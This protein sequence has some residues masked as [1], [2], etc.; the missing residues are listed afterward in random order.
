MIRRTLIPLGLSAATLLLTLGTAQAQVIR[1][2]SLPGSPTFDCANPTNARERDACARYEEGRLEGILSQGQSSVGRIGADAASPVDDPFATP[3]VAETPTNI[4]GPTPETVEPTPEVVDALPTVAP[5]LAPLQL[6]APPPAPVDA[7]QVAA[8]PVPAPTADPNLVSR[9]L[10]AM[11]GLDDQ[12][13][14][15]EQDIIPSPLGVEAQTRRNT[16]RL[17]LDDNQGGQA[18]EAFGGA[19]SI[20]IIGG[21]GGQGLPEGEITL[22][23]SPD[24]GLGEEELLAAA[25][26]GS[27][28]NTSVLF[29][30]DPDLLAQAGDILFGTLVTR[31]LSTAPSAIIGEIA[32]PGPLQG[33][34]LI[35]SFSQQYD[36]LLITF[37]RLSLPDGR[38]ADIEAVAIDANT[39]LSTLADDVAYHT[40]K[41]Y[42]LAAGAAFLSGFGE[43]LAGTD[44]VIIVADDGTVRTQQ[45]EQSL[46]EALSGGL[47]AGA[48]AITRDVEFELQRLRTP[49]VVV[50]EGTTIGLVLLKDIVAQDRD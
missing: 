1:F 48:E 2:P 11:Q 7:Q 26:V 42:A 37:N 43:A 3:Q 18:G 50:R 23:A 15:L 31:A 38:F 12:Q 20:E 44:E 9:Y 47:A 6:V 45:T 35:G 49:T 46:A 4:L 24:S 10:T 8:V 19:G 29:E 40:L 5:T 21:Q 39:S 30:A 34:R 33:A 14:F 28:G 36:R 17:G 22:E 16:T 32:S 41:R 13:V 25:G 27:A